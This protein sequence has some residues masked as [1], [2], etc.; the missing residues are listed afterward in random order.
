MVGSFVAP[1]GEVVDIDG[2]DDAD[3]GTVVGDL[4]TTDGTTVG[5]VVASLGVYV[6]ILGDGDGIADGR[7]G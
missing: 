3:G 2:I 4:L 7:V 6:A 5:R 1:L